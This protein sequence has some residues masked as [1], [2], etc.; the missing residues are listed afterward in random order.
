MVGICD[1]NVL[2]VWS[3]YC[4]NLRDLWVAARSTRSDSL[5]GAAVGLAVLGIKSCVFMHYAAASPATGTGLA[6][7]CCCRCRSRAGRTKPPRAEAP[8]TQQVLC[9]CGSLHFEAAAGCSSTLLSTAESFVRVLSSPQ[10]KDT[11]EMSVAEKLAAAVQQKD[12]GNAL[13]KAGQYSKAVQKYEKAVQ[14]I[15]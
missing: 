12:K 15:E 3:A 8:F 6:A 9:I 5:D 1:P 4:P 11:W 2:P 10:A 14:C 13:F 7:G